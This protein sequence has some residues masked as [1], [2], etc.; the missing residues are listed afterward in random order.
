M[1]TF[2]FSLQGAWQNVADGHAIGITVTG[3]IIVFFALTC[4]SLC[5]AAVPHVL[6]VVNKFFPEKIE[7]PKK[8]VAPA[9]TPDDVI[10][11]ISVAFHYSLQPSE[12]Q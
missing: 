10:A 12:N 6:V 3:M 7:T 11:A 8:I 2:V 9:G 5:I 1:L 4:I